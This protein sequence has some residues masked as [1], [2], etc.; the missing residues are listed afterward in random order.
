MFVG[1]EKAVR[2]T[3]A[4]LS[5]Y[6]VINWDALDAYLNLWLVPGSPRALDHARQAGEV[7]RAGLLFDS[8]L[9][10]ADIVD[11]ASGHCV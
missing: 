11:S 8:S 4:T 2:F 6:V 3:S 7:T 1:R 5:F 10:F 9:G